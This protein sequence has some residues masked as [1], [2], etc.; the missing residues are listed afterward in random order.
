[1]LKSMTGYG[2]SEVNIGNRKF[3]IEMKSVNHRFLEVMFK[4]PKELMAF[5]DT[6]KKTLQEYIK[7]GRVDIFITIE[8][9]ESST[10]LQVDWNL[11]RQY[12]QLMKDMK[13][14][15]QLSGSIELKDLLT[16]P[17]LVQSKPEP[18]DMEEWKEEFIVSFD[19]AC[20]VLVH[21]REVEGSSLMKDFQ[22]R[23]NF[24]GEILN[25]I[26]SKTSIVVNEYREKLINRINEWLGGSI[27]LDE[28][29]LL[30]EVAFFTDKAN[31]DEEITRLKSHFAQF[32]INLTTEEPVGRKLDFLVQE[33]NREM[34]TM[35]S[36]A[37]HLELSQSVI[38]LKSELEKIREQ[39]QNIE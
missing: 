10:Q 24:M 17:D 22:S 28:A 25:N 31:I 4:M 34:N 3:I 29:R 14:Q 26:E 21:M 23:I 37:N 7:R 16:I 5:E 13:D 9:N 32:L 11:A 19:G 38:E 6:L 30:N 39:V 27:E 1:M 18:T 15:F 2:R 33:M 8:N 20:K 36:K 12:I 35:G